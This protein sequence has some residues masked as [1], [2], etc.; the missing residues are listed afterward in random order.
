M[1]T[2]YQSINELYEKSGYLARHGSDVYITVFIVVAVLLII[3][4]YSVMSKIKPL[5]ANW[6]KERCNPAVLPFAGLVYSPPGKNAFEATAD[7]FAQC[8][9]TVT[10]NLAGY[11]IQPLQYVLNIITQI[12]V[13]ISKAIHQIR[14][15]FSKVRGNVEN[16]TRNVMGRTLNIMIPLQQII[17]GIK[18]SLEKVS[19]IGTAAIFSIYGAYLGLK[20]FIGSII[21]FI[22][23]FLVMFAAVIVAAWILPFT[24]PLAILGTIAWVIVATI[25]IYVA[26][27]YSRTM[28]GSTRRKIPKKPKK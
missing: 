21:E 13:I 27:E 2:I 18:S 7:N 11:A 5:R 12:F 9:Q 1:D 23:I 19:G 17:I 22:I 24:W 3:S 28:R 26:V 8:G 10:Q 14:A 16:L 6:V 15:L 4:Y 25:L 20:S